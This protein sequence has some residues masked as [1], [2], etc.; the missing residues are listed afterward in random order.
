MEFKHRQP[1][2]LP[3][4][5]LNRDRQ[6]VSAFLCPDNPRVGCQPKQPCVSR[7]RKLRLRHIHS[8][9]GRRIQATLPH[10]A[11]NSD[12]LPSW[13]TIEE[14]FEP[15]TDYDSIIERIAALPELLRH[16]FIDHHDG[17][18]FTVVA[19]VENPA[20]L[21][22]NLENVEIA[23]RNRGPSRVVV[24]RTV[25]RRFSDDIERKTQITLQRRIACGARG[26]HAR[27]GAN[28]GESIANRIGRACGLRILR[29]D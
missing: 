12:D 25:R 7:L 8:R 15:L 3:Q 26:K 21:H 13:L 20:A 17:R 27:Y 23:W 11:Y 10:I 24:I 14:I 9:L 4:L 29:A 18:R 22:W 5:F 6:F 1:R 28:T 19:V 2:G 16:T